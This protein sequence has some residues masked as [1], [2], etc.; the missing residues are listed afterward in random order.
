MNF[1]SSYRSPADCPDP[2]WWFVFLKDK[3]LVQ[4]SGS[5]VRVPQLQNSDFLRERL[6]RTQYLGMLDT[7]HCYCAV[8]EKEDAV[9]EGM[10]PIA[11]RD[12]FGQV[13][14]DLF[15][16][17]ARASSIMYWDSTNK[18][19]GQCG[20]PV[21]LSASERAKVCPSCGFTS[22][23]RISPAVIVA[24]IKGKQILLARS[25]RFP[26]NLYS[27]PAGFVEPGETFEE[28]VVREVKEETG[29]DVK[30]IR[31]FASQPWPFPDSLMIGFTAE[32]G[33][34]EIRADGEEVVDAG[35]YTSENLPEIPAIK[36][37]ISRRLIDWF[38]E[39]NR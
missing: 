11:L 7:V 30:N 29:I 38:V 33:G 16:V 1:H 2:A 8:A 5:G 28:C 13:S 36:S 32:Y 4:I 31:Y 12:L 34:G 3:V 15:W 37:S 9:F 18:F 39:R 26:R 21:R 22:Y 20:Q 35:W 23:P 25:R 19:C 24:V 27:V 6:A 10:E 14:D 17:A